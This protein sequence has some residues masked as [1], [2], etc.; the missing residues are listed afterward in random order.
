MRWSVVRSAIGIAATSIRLAP[1]LIAAR[2][3]DAS[4]RL[5]GV[6]HALALLGV[7]ETPSRVRV[8]TGGRSSLVWE[9]TL[10]SGAFVVKRAL[11]SGSVLARGARLAGPQ[12]YPAEL[13][14]SA[15]IA[16]EVTALRALAVAGVRVPRVIAV[17]VPAAVMLVEKLDGASLLGTVFKLSKYEVQVCETNMG[18]VSKLSKYGPQPREVSSAATNTTSTSRASVSTTFRRLE[19]VT[20]TSWIPSL[21]SGRG[22]SPATL[23]S[24]I[25]SPS[26]KL[27]RAY[28]SALDR[29]HAAGW[30]LNDAHPGNALVDGDDIALIDLEFAERSTDPARVEFDLAYAAQYFTAAERAIFLADTRV[31]ETELEGY[32]P[33]FAYEANRLRA[34]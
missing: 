2:V 15:R 31:D 20:L 23:T 26:E 5:L 8:L 33:L 28:R 17:N 3:E 7:V 27:I 4:T 19:R 30:V 21:T 11:E 24:W 22:V 9:V 29:A 18:T 32:A 25:P 10:S 14:P 1:S 34:A 12:P 16:R 13:S 6:R